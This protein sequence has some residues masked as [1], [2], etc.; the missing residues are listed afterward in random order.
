MGFVLIEDLLERLK[1]CVFIVREDMVRVR[2]EGLVWMMGLV[3]IEEK[4]KV[5]FGLYSWKMELW[6]KMVLR[7]LYGVGDVVLF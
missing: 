2:E 6:K 4:I 1:C 5:C 3:K 7:W